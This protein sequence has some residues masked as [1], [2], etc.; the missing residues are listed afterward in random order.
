LA[1]RAAGQLDQGW[2]ESVAKVWHHFLIER[3]LPYV[4]RDCR[5]RKTCVETP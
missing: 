3:L 1:A 5:V 4:E 2:P